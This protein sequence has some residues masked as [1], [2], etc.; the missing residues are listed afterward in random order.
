MHKGEACRGWLITSTRDKYWSI[1][2]VVPQ[3]LLT[4]CFLLYVDCLRSSWLSDWLT[5]WITV[6]RL[7]LW[8]WFMWLL[9]LESYTH[10][11]FPLSRRMTPLSQTRSLFPHPVSRVQTPRQQTER[12][13]ALAVTPPCLAFLADVPGRWCDGLSTVRWCWPPLWCG[14]WWMCSCCSTSASATN[15]MIGKTARCSRPCEVSSHTTAAAPFIHRMDPM[16]R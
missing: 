2:N 6:G 5:S 9:D 13:W 10:Q 7:K 3:I 8:S 4:P 11:V 16:G 15:V 12:P 14:C 1:L